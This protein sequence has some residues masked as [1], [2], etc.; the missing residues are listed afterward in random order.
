[1]IFAFLFVYMFLTGFKKE[2]YEIFIS[3]FGFL[4]FLHQTLRLLTNIPTTIF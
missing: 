2:R 4:D 3:F 1:M